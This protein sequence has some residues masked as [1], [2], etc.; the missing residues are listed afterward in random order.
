MTLNQLVSY[1]SKDLLP[2]G[3]ATLQRS[4]I[5]NYLRQHIAIL[6][7]NKNVSHKLTYDKMYE[8]F[9][10]DTPKDK[11]TVRE[12]IATCLNYWVGQGLIKH[13]DNIMQRRQ[14]YAIIIDV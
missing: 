1:S 5:A 4:V 3:N 6:Q 13:W 12:Y 2:P 8:A 9:E 7:R 14:Y 11:I 10:A